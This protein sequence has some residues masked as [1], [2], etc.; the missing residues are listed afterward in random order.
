[1]EI[2]SGLIAKTGA[3]LAAL[4]VGGTGIYLAKNHLNNSISKY[5][6]ALINFLEKAKHDIVFDVKTGENENT[7]LSDS[8]ITFANGKPQKVTVSAI[9][10]VSGTSNSSFKKNGGNASI[11]DEQMKEIKDLNGGNWTWKCK[12]SFSRGTETSSETIKSDYKNRIFTSDN[13]G[14]FGILKKDLSNYTGSGDKWT[15][16]ELKLVKMD[17]VK[18]CGSSRDTSKNK[19]INGQ[20]STSDLTIVVDEFIMDKREGSELIPSNPK[21]F[22]QWFDAQYATKQYQS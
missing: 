3:V 13:R 15:K 14:L 18:R 12:L 4:C 21:L 16:D 5:E 7:D 10:Q 22:D 17:F 6:W 1:M 2:S 19:E 20:K 9:V 11:N 8:D